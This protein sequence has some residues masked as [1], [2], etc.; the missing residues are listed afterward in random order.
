MPVLTRLCYLLHLQEE[1]ILRRMI[2]SAQTAGLAISLQSL[3]T[4]TLAA[5]DCGSADY[6][7]MVSEGISTINKGLMAFVLFETC[8]TFDRALHNDVV[9][10]GAAVAQTRDV[11]WGAGS[12]GWWCWIGC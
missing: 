6:A 9:R 7:N 3:A 11:R 1:L 12:G 10:A 4:F 2:E 8:A 5:A